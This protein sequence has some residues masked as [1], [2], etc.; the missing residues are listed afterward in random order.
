M[1]RDGFVLSEADPCWFT[2]GEGESRV[3][4]LV[5]VDDCLL[6]GKQAATAK[7]KQDI[8]KLFEIEDRGAICH[9]LGM[10]VLRDYEQHAIWVGQR[11]YVLNII[12]RFGMKECKPRITPFEANKQIVKEGQALGDEVPYR[13]LVGS[14]LYLCQCT[15]PDVAHSVGAQSLHDQ[16]NQGSLGGSQVRSPLPVRYISARTPIQGYSRTS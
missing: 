3:Y 14:L 13:E 2:C 4:V 16:S 8:G 9:F 1:V 10:E 15:R 11:H 6:V 12:E 7:T 5:H